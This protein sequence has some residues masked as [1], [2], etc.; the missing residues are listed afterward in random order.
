MSRIRV[1]L[2]NCSDCCQLT[3]IRAP[4]PFPATTASTFECHWRRG[5]GTFPNGKNEGETRMLDQRQH[6]HFQL[7]L[8]ITMKRKQ[9]SYTTMTYLHDLLL[10]TRCG[11]YKY[12]LSTLFAKKFRG[13]DVFSAGLYHTLFNEI[14]FKFANPHL[15]FYSNIFRQINFCTI[16]G[17]YLIQ[18]GRKK[19]LP[20]RWDFCHF[21]PRVEG[22]SWG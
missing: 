10:K 12:L 11:N 6:I 9:F 4:V 20:P 15:R 1:S 7:S 5:R 19:F 8:V 22:L 2:R 13:S 3:Q 17:Q 14:I 16:R 18:G 21:P